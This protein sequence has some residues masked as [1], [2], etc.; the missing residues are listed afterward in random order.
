[1]KFR[2]GTLFVAFIVLAIFLG[3][4]IGGYQEGNAFTIWCTGF[5]VGVAASAFLGWHLESPRTLVL[6]CILAGVLPHLVF[7]VECLFQSPWTE[8]LRNTDLG[9]DYTTSVDYMTAIGG[10]ASAVGVVLCLLAG[11]FARYLASK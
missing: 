8:F 1:M 4:R 5:F 11:F 3:A 6:V 9:R 2:L 7:V 10:M